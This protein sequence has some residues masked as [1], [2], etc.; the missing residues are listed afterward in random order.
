MDNDIA[1]AALAV[2]LID[3]YGR[4]AR[5]DSPAFPLP[6]ATVLARLICLRTASDVPPVP[7]PR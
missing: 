7:A 5:Y 2:G 3:L 4:K 6:R 1:L